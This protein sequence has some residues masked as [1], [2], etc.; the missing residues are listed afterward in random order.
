[1]LPSLPDKQV[2]EAPTLHRL[3]LSRCAAQLAERQPHCRSAHIAPIHSSGTALYP[4]G[5]LSKSNHFM[6]Q[7]RRAFHVLPT[8]DKNLP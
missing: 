8:Y 2:S 6:R 1:M 5:R 3:G 4:L 7:F